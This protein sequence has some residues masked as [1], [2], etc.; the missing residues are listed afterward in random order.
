MKRILGVILVVYSIWITSCEDSNS[1]NYGT[2]EIKSEIINP[3]VSI[4]KD[5]ITKD[6]SIQL[7]EVDSIKSIYVRIL[8]S[9]IKLHPTK[10]DENNGK[11]I[12]DGPFLYS[13]L[14]ETNEQIQT[15]FSHSIETGIYEKIKFE[16][17]R[18]S[19]SELSNY[20]NVPEFKDFATNE[21]YSIIITGKKFKDNKS[22]DFTYFSN[23]TANLSFNFDTPIEIKE[24]TKQTLAIQIDP[25]QVFKKSGSILDPTNPKNFSDIEN[26]IKQTIKV[27]KKS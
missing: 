8:I 5:Q 23:V 20:Q 13:I 3:H 6:H 25:L 14:N 27:V 18:F 21:R 19:T 24:G 15:S 9:E 12:K 22:T 16:I 10:N 26:A 11:L 4:I 7:N 2:I 1:P 17:H